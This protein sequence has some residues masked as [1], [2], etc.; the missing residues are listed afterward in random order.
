MA[1]S[2]EKGAA[3]FLVMVESLKKGELVALK[4]GY[5]YRAKESIGIILEENT[6][7][8]KIWFCFSEF[9]FEPRWVANSEIFSLTK[10]KF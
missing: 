1:F 5:K 2:K 3:L 8:C 10:K 7:M 6:P 9:E 4:K